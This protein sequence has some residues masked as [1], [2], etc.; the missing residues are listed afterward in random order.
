MRKIR[1]QYLDRRVARD[2]ALIEE[3]FFAARCALADL[4]GIMPEFEPKALEKVMPVE[5]MLAEIAGLP[6]TGGGVVPAAGVLPASGTNTL[7][8]VADE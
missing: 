4:E 5:A 8:P 3:L 7:L 1:E 2:Q 6:L